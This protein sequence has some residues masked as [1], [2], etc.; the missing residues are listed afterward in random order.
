MQ[1]NLD[2]GTLGELSSLEYLDLSRNNIA[3]LPNG[4][5]SRISRLKTLQFSVNT[6]RK[7]RRF[8]FRGK[9]SSNYHQVL[10]NCLS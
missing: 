5:L 1:Q 9:L 7:V 3:D 4:T 6:L 10:S 8:F 2:S